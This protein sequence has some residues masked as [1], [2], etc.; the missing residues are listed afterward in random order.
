MCVCVGGVLCVVSMCVMCVERIITMYGGAICLSMDLWG[1]IESLWQ[2][3][4]N[5][6]WA[7]QKSKRDSNGEGGRFGATWAWMMFDWDLK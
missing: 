3:E 4:G 5:K 6:E 1:R 2:K 7:Q